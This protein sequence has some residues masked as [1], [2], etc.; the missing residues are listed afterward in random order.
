MWFGLNGKPIKYVKQGV[1]TPTLSS[2]VCPNI[3]VV[4]LSYLYLLGYPYI[5]WTRSYEARY[6]LPKTNCY[7][8][9]QKNLIHF[10]LYFVMED[11]L[12]RPTSQKVKYVTFWLGAFDKPKKLGQILPSLV[13]WSKIK[14]QVISYLLIN[15][16][17]SG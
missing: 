14:Q 11:Y 15:Y 9:H 6:T 12:L 13:Y 2:T 3:N 7:Q 4:G 5:V 8:I 10:C 16:W 1:C 17:D